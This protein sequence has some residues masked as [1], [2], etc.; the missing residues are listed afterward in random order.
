M[1]AP[2]SK[3]QKRE[4]PNV[5]HALYSAVAK[6]GDWQLMASNNQNAANDS[7]NTEIFENSN[8]L[9]NKNRQ[10]F[11]QGKNDYIVVLATACIRLQI[12]TF[13]SPI[14]R[15][16]CDTGAQT[17]LITNACVKRIGLPTKQC[18]TPLLG[19]AGT[20]IS[21]RKV[22][23]HISPRF[24]NNYRLYVEFQVNDEFCSTHPNFSLNALK[25]IDKNVVLADDQF[26]VPG[27]IDI[28]L[29]ADVW[30]LIMNANIYTHPTGAIMHDTALGHIILGRTHDT[31]SIQNK[32]V[33]LNAINKEREITEEEL[34]HENMLQRFFDA[35]EIAEPSK[36]FTQDEEAAERFF[37]ANTYKHERGFY[38]TKIPLIPGKTLGESRNIVMRRFYALERK[39]QTN[40]SLR[41]EYI[42]FMQEFIALGHMQIAPP[43]RPGVMHYYIPHHAVRTSQKFRSVFD[44]SCKTSNGESL[45]SMQI[46]GLKLQ[47]D[48]HFQVIRF[49]RHKHAV[50]ADIV[51]M[52]RQIAIDPSQWDLQRIFLERIAYATTSGISYY[53]RYIWTCIVSFCGC[54]LNNQMRNGS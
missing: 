20:S 30:G 31:Q 22:Q 41:Q 54:T 11:T 12:G 47:C 17:S 44:A 25:P 52:F 48:L 6:I 9:N 43:I 27:S 46:I 23:A 37:I 26:D 28:L 8:Q 45:N 36:Y 50:V 38:V 51:E 24:N 1:N 32:S 15:A 3:K 16:I 53:T 49:R 35:E 7:K 40:K 33:F 5:K 14:C 29:G 4:K 2:A 34:T 19:V 21:T 13:I 39:L 18:Y 42:A 10:K